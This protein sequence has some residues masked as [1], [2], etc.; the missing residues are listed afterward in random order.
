MLAVP[1]ALLDVL[2]LR[3]GSEVGITVDSGNLVVKP[4][5]RPRYKLDELLSR[6]DSRAARPRK[7]R[8]WVTDGPVGRELI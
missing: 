3:P 5:R 7:D 1:P 4:L 2:D 6:C 8:E